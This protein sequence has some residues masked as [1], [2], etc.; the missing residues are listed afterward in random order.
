MIDRIGTFLGTVLESTLG[1]SSGGFPQWVAR[2]QADKKY[3]ND[4]EEMKHF[5]I[6]EPG[7]VDWNFPA[8]NDPTILA[9]LVL[10]TD[11]GPLK[12]YEQLCSAMGWAGDDFQDLTTFA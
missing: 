1:Q 10:F 3:V 7:S 12:N 11:K 2:L 8:P 5:G 4:P 9:Y 6:A